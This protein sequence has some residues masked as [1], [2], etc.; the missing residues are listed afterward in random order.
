MLSRYAL[1]MRTSAFS[2][3][4]AVACVVALLGGCT[5]V[6]DIQ[7]DDTAISLSDLRSLVASQAK[8]P[9]SD[10][11]VVLDARLPKSYQESHIP[12][13]QLIDILSID[14][15]NKRVDARIEKFETKV[16]YGDDPGDSIARAVVK[17]MLS[18][19]YDNV[20]LFKG[21]WREWQGA[22]G[23]SGTKKP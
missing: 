9:K 3:I 8:D 1:D 17:K 15:R 10:T 7:V 14:D 12:G 20:R 2:V 13:A 21:G 11:V 4:G 6:S 18:A 22:G 16:V 19:G 5:K 23:A